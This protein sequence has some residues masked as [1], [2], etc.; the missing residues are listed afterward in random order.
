MPVT[1]QGEIMQVFNGQ[2]VRSN[3]VADCRADSVA[4]LVDAYNQ[5][6]GLVNFRAT[7]WGLLASSRDVIRSAAKS[8]PN[9]QDAQNLETLAGQIDTLLNSHAQG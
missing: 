4:A 3:L 9:P 6:D 2:H 7:A 8:A 5:H 1:L